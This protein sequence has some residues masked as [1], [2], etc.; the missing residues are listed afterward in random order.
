M[1]HYLEKPIVG[2]GFGYT[3]HNIYL[4]NFITVRAE[5]CSPLHCL[6]HLIASY[7]PRSSSFSLNTLRH[8]SVK[9]K[10]R[11]HALFRPPRFTR[12]AS[13]SANSHST[14]ILL[15][16]NLAHQF[17][18]L[19]SPHIQPTPLDLDLI[20]EFDNPDKSDDFIPLS[21]DEKA[22]LYSP[23]KF[24]VIIKLFGKAIGHQLL[25]AKLQSLWKPTKPLHLIDLGSAFFSH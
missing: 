19:L 14:K 6:L 1:V 9:P 13:R 22:R 2:A 21:A 7:L 18:T 3:V 24:S 10:P 5:N 16:P 20:D 4:A 17:T 8:E 11:F 12:H 23:R 25:K 15:S